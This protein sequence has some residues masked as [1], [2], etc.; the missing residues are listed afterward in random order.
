MS[1]RI[2]LA[3]FVG[4]GLL[5]ALALAAFVA[6]HASKA[7]DGL[8]RVAQDNGFAAK[9]DGAEVWKHA[10][11]SDYAV[12]GVKHGGL[13]T[14]LAGVLGTLAVFVAALGLAFILRKRRHDGSASAQHRE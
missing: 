9:A 6:P 10:P 13:S 14:A 1:R 8:D 7:P 5:L 11:A 4:S 3:L 2:S 12:P